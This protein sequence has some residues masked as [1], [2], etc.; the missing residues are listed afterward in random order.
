[1]RGGTPDIG[2]MAARHTPLTTVPED[3]EEEPGSPLREPSDS[4]DAPLSWN[5]AP[6]PPSGVPPRPSVGPRT[7][8]KVPDFLKEGQ[9][10]GVEHN[11]TGK[12]TLKNS[13][14]LKVP[15]FLEGSRG[16]G[17]PAPPSKIARRG[18]PQPPSFLHSNLGLSAPESV[19]A[20]AHSVEPP[21]SHQ[22]YSYMLAR[23]CTL[24]LNWPCGQTFECVS[25]VC[26]NVPM[27]GA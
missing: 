3:S 7:A 15:E 10:H 25:V 4:L 23:F 2:A 1:M 5:A 19:H 24:F 16:L 9:H 14:G 26:K 20:R 18:P 12:A 21:E 17:S 27:T 6:P 8:L 11:A 22:V 13:R